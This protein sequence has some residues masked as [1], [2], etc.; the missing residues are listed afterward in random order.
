M[1]LFIKSIQHEFA[2][3]LYSSIPSDIQMIASRLG[4]LPRE[5]VISQADLDPDEAIRVAPSA[6]R[7][8]IHLP[9]AD[10]G[11]GVVS[12]EGRARAGSFVKSVTGMLH[13]LH[14]LKC[15]WMQNMVK[16]WMSVNSR[17]SV[18]PADG[19][20]NHGYRQVISERQQLF[21]PNRD[22]GAAG[23]KC[24]KLP[25][26]PATLKITGDAPSKQ[27]YYD[28]LKEARTKRVQDLRARAKRVDLHSVE[29]RA[30]QA[31]E[32]H[33][34]VRHKRGQG[35]PISIMPTMPSLVMKDDAYRRFITEVL[36]F[37][38]FSLGESLLGRRCLCYQRPVIDE[39]HC[40]NCPILGQS[41][42][43]DAV[44]LMVGRE[45]GQ[46]RASGATVETEP[47]GAKC[48]RG[49]DD[50]KGP[51]ALLSH[52]GHTHFLDFKSV[53]VVAPTNRESAYK[54]LR[55]AR[56][57]GDDDTWI[58]DAG[59]HSQT[60]A[61]QSSATGSQS[62]LTRRAIDKLCHQVQHTSAD[63]KCVA[64][65]GATLTAVPLTTTG[66]IHPNL[67]KVLREHIDK[68]E[69][70][71][72]RCNFGWDCPDFRS[73]IFQRAAVTAINTHGAHSLRC[74]SVIARKL[75]V[76]LPC[77]PKCVCDMAP[78]PHLSIE[79]IDDSDDDLDD[80]REAEDANGQ[81]LGPG[82]DV[83]QRVFPVDNSTTTDFARIVS[84]Q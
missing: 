64:K 30:A 4:R 46:A 76:P 75:D 57:Q 21:A 54:D 78:A 32:L 45:M 13:L 33:A 56:R 55:L 10:L 82:D 27:V 69:E 71:D 77:P 52:T 44:K 18:A 60:N 6:Q 70:F 62:S 74:M 16:Q 36:G 7:L 22:A 43:H 84:T 68:G 59:S 41:A 37:A 5:F 63:A 66:V 8:I 83:Y 19:S 50:L 38:P 25:S 47:R 3:H 24:T 2:H 23:V 65:L 72:D 11:F 80:V 26:N 48:G 15:P 9:Q 40:V 35:L 49:D 17:R 14:E 58:D 29:G 34:Q 51:D 67:H 53:N 28:L 73:C 1:V 20:L 39:H 81:C 79:D 42:A 61:S 31:W 12:H